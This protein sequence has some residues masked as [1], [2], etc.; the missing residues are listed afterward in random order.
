MKIV[1]EKLVHRVYELQMEQT[2][3]GLTTDQI[4]L[5]TQKSPLPLLRN[6]FIRLI[7]MNQLIHLLAQSS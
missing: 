2:S 1:S 6:L 3:I 5:L 4:Y 7:A